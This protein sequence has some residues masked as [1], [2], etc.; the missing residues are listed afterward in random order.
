MRNDKSSRLTY[1]SHMPLY[2]VRWPAFNVSLVRARNEEELIDTL[3]EVC[4]PGACRWAVYKGP[5]F[6]DFDLPVKPKWDE[7]APSPLNDA[8]VELEGVEDLETDGD[9]FNL[10]VP[11]GDAASEMK[12]AIGRWAFPHLMRTIEEA[13]EFRPKKKALVKALRA[14]VREMIQYNWRT[15]QRDRRGDRETGILMALG[16]TVAPPWLKRIMEEA[17][18]NP[19]PAPPGVEDDAPPEPSHDPDCPF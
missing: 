13:G 9:I 1:A 19:K 7:D 10:S 14:E 3:D 18:A 12:R 17:K 2:V 16:L 5:V 6:I 8:G 11:D 4:D 15:A